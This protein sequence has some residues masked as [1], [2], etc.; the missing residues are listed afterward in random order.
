V[1]SK[2]LINSRIVGSL[3]TDH[4]DCSDRNAVALGA[5]IRWASY[6]NIFSTQD[7]AAAAGGI[8]RA[9]VCHQGQSLTEH[10]DYLDRSFAFQGCEPD[11]DDGGDATLY[12]LL[13][14]RVEGRRE[15]DLI[16]VPTYGKKKKPSLP[17]LK[18]DGR[19]TPGWFTKTGDC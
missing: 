13:G 17:R 19:E 9:C 16:M 18:A 6:E 4:S 15:T 8:R 7:H 2:P 12:V 10:W 1:K 3:H 11:H 14:A 5:D